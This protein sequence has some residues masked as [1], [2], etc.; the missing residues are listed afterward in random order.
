MCIYPQYCFFCIIYTAY[1]NAEDDFKKIDQIDDLIRLTK[2]YRNKDYDINLNDQQK[3]NVRMLNRFILEYIANKD[4]AIKKLS[5][6]LILI[7]FVAAT[8]MKIK[9]TRKR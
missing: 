4:L 8:I 3:R 9:Q 1:L 2:A 5:T 6:I 7:I